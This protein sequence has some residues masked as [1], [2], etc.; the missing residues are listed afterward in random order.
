M[1]LQELFA[2]S[3]RPPEPWREG[4][5]IPWDDPDFSRRMLQEHL[6]QE[7]DGASRR[8]EKIDAHVDF[9]LRAVLPGRPCRLL[10]LGC[11]PGLYVHRLAARGHDCTG[12]DFAPASIAYA[13]EQADHL[14]L[15]CRF[16]S[17]DIRQTDFGNGFD[18]IML[19]YGELNLFP[20]PEALELLR[21][22]VSA[23]APQGQVL[24]EVHSYEAVRGRGN[25]PRTWRAVDS[26]LFLDRPHLRLDESF[27]LPDVGASAGRHW[28]VDPETSEVSRHAW[29]MQAYGDAE[30]AALLAEAGLVLVKAYPS[31]SGAED[32]AGFPVLL[33]S[34]ARSW[35]GSAVQ[36][37]GVAG[38]MGS[39]EVHIQAERS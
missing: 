2:A 15:R 9:I 33:A 20:R 25:A 28:I 27:W 22:C 8:F 16:L 17:G 32:G 10:D 4:R 19:T 7:H 12:I 11:G 31:L 18:L 13:R 38:A 29:T 37:A 5:T 24:L 3:G 14:G 26:G 21:R 30:Y 23:L 34:P 36:G 35:V 1:N 6:S 39:T